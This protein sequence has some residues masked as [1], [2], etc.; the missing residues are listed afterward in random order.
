MLLLLPLLACQDG[1]SD[2]ASCGA[3]SLVVV[4][5][6]S[7]AVVCGD[8]LGFDVDVGG[9]TLV[10]P[11]GGVE[12]A[13]SGHV[14]VALNGQDVA[15]SGEERFEIPDVAPGAKQVRVELSRADHTPLEPYTG[16]VLYITVDPAACGA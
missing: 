11:Y 1:G 7:D 6:A 10:D 4:S 5:P 14:D 2:S 8:P 9:I 15:M 12:D 16:A 13:C 3:P